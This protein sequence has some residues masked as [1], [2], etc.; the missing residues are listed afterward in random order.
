MTK[1]TERYG[2]LRRAIIPELH[3][4]C[5]KCGATGIV[6]GNPKLEDCPHCCSGY[7]TLRDIPV[8]DLLNAKESESKENADVAGDFEE[9]HPW[10]NDK[11]CYTVE[12]TNGTVPVAVMLFKGSLDT[13]KTVHELVASMAK[14]SETVSLMDSRRT[15]VVKCYGK[16]ICK[17]FSYNGRE[18]SWITGASQ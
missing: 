18:L 16:D 11:N 13:A 14:T 9:Y 8:K 12:I 4:P 3:V 10:S 1:R 5:E 7:R 6:D 17:H 2:D 15:I